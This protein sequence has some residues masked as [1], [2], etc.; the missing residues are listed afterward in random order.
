MGIKRKLD[1]YDDGG[2]RNVEPGIQR[3]SVLDISMFKLQT[4][5]VRRVEPSLLRSVLILNTLKH[6]ECELQKEGVTSDFSEA[7]SMTLN[8]TSDM[9]MDVLP[10][11]E[12]IGNGDIQPDLSE[13]HISSSM[14]TTSLSIPKDTVNPLPP[15]ESFVELS[16]AFPLSNG[17]LSCG[18]MKVKNSDSKEHFTN[19][20]QNM[21]LNFPVKTEDILTD[22]DVSTCDFD[23]F[24]SLAS[25]MKL[26]PLSAEEVMHS[27]PVHDGYSTLFSNCSQVGA[28]CKSDL[29]PEDIDNIMQILVGT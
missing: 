12:S 1:E 17:S 26:T 9:S 21:Q 7:A 19:S 22:I 24:S 10:D 4:H 29:M 16:S 6:I 3:Q 18:P 8:E 15:I 28:S 14:E 11:C 20:E 13:L 5:P 2:E 27:F 23:I 25:S